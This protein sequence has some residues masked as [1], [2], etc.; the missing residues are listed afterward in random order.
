VS[1]VP[2]LAVTALLVV[3]LLL[4]LVVLARLSAMRRVV[5]ATG[6]GAG[7]VPGMPT[8]EPAPPPTGTEPAEFTSITVDGQTVSAGLLSG[9]TLVGFFATDCS[10]CKELIP[11]FMDYAEAVPGGRGQVLAVITGDLDVAAKLAVLLDTVASVVVEA[12]QGP[13]ATAFGVV[14]F[15][16]VCLLDGRR[17][18]ASAF[19]VNRLPAPAP[20]TPS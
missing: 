11:R 2:V 15:P 16:V 10:S 8:R 14:D 13:V 12:G 20:G 6:A 18:M 7:T 4:T 19:D 3:N 5:F 17:I 1:T 9:V